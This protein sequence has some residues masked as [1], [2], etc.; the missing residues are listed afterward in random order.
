MTTRLSKRSVV[1]AAGALAL[2]SVLFA[3]GR[4][5]PAGEHDSYRTRLRQLRVRSAE[6]EQGILRAHMGLPRAHGEPREELA[7]LRARAEELRDVPSFLAEPEQR[8][9]G[10]VL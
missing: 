7:G 4:P 3:L 2:L 6:L 8:T 1:L 5:M 10:A 9:L